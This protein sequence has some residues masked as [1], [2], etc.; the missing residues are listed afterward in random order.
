MKIE[1]G[2][3]SFV[4]DWESVTKD[5]TKIVDYSVNKDSI[6]YTYDNGVKLSQVAYGYVLTIPNGSFEEM[7]SNEI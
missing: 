7:N 6:D 1:R 2:I 5:A 4:K 3:T